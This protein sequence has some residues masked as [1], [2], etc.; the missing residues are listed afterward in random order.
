MLDINEWYKQLNDQ[1]EL[2]S[3]LQQRCHQEYD[4][5]LVITERLWI[6]PENEASGMHKYDFVIPHNL[7]FWTKQEQKLQKHPCN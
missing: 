6:A 7:F 5:L 2:V 1:L 3:P 4:A